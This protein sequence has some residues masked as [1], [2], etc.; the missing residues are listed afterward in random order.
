MP[1]SLVFSHAKISLNPCFL[2]FWST[3]VDLYSLFKFLIILACL[4]FIFHSMLATYKHKNVTGAY[5][6]I[7]LVYR[8]LLTKR[9]PYDRKF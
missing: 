9:L 8:R 4:L 2:T 7:M 1:E 3:E 5:L 6:I